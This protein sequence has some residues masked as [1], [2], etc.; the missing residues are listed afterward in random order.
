MTDYEYIMTQCRKYHFKKWNEEELALCQSLLASL[1]RQELLSLYRCRWLGDNDELKKTVFQVLFADKVGKR[2]ERIKGLS[3]DELIKEF[4]ERNTNNR[5][6]I[7]KEMRERY[8][9]NRDKYKIADIFNSST[10]GDQQWV[11]SQI[12]KEKR[13]L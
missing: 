11:A 6:L 3:T 10:K 8:K 7:R 12:R 13:Q 1:S 4:R 2:E 9:T 5:A